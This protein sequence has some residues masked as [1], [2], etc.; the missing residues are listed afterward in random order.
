MLSDVTDLLACP[1][2]ASAVELETDGGAKVLVCV[3]GHR[4]D[5][6]RQGYVSLV[7][8]AP[9]KFEGDTSDMLEARARFLD[10]GHYDPLV[11]AV[12]AVVD[13]D[14]HSGQGPRVLEVGAGTGHYL[15]GVL[16]RSAGSRGVGLDVSKYAARRIAKSHPRVGAVVA[17]AWAGLPL[18]DRAMT[19]VLCVFAPRNAGESHRVLAPGGRLTVLTPTGRHLSELIDAFGMV[20]VDER[21]VERLDAATAE[22]FAPAQRTDV[23]FSMTLTHADVVRVVGMGPTARH[24]GPDALSAKVAELPQPATVTAS[25]TVS[26]Y[27]RH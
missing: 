21:K 27:E 6:A 1:Q 18:R 13:R 3:L 17:D 15:A 9:S 22:H 4:F 10:A 23:E 2:C 24:L 11:S 16:D 7:S 5:V 19:D 25:V 14:D 8:G 20:N 12:A 26:T